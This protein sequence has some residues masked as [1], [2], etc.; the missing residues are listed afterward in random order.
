[1]LALYTDSITSYM[2]SNKGN[3]MRRK[4]TGKN[5]YVTNN[6]KNMFAKTKTSPIL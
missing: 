4:D 1:M 2:G 3:S 5:R 6:M